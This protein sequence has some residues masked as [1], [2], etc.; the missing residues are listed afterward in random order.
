MKKSILFLTLAF[1][2]LYGMYSC[3]KE[4]QV[5][6]T[7]ET[8]LS[9]LRDSIP[10]DS[11]DTF[12]PIDTLHDTIQ[13]AS[14]RLNVQPHVTDSLLRLKVNTQESYFYYYQWLPFVQTGDFPT[15]KVQVLQ[16]KGI[17]PVTTVGSPA[18]FSVLYAKKLTRGTFPFEINF[19]TNN[20]TG[21]VYVTDSGYHFS[22]AHDSIIRINP[23]FV[24]F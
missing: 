11:T 16:P 19:R 9:K 15:F 3:T 14:Y 23:K 10:H 18:G 2:A 5:R 17:T 4:N 8:A 20:Y 6:L 13:L 21:Q 24:R 12:P 22:W 7:D 1:G